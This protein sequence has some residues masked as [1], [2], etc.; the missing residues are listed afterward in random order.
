[1][2]NKD[3]HHLHD[4]VKKKLLVCAMLLIRKSEGKEELLLSCL[5][6]IHHNDLVAEITMTANEF[7]LLFTYISNWNISLNLLFILIA[8]VYLL[9]TGPLAA[10][11][12]AGS[13]VSPKKKLSFLFGLFL[14]YFSFGSPLAMLSHELFSMHM[15]QMS[16][17]YIVMP[18]FLLLGLPAWLVRPALGFQWVS[19]IGRFL[20]KPI[21]ILFV[22][23]GAI[24]LYHIPQVFDFL[25]SDMLYHLLSHLVLLALALCMWWPVVCPI[26]ELD[27]IKHLHKLGFIFANGVLLTPVCALIIFADQPL[28][29]TFREMS[30]VAPLMSPLHD[31][32]LGG[33]IMKIAQEIVYITAIGF[34]F[35]RWFRIQRQ[36]DEQEMLEWQQGEVSAIGKKQ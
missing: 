28:F 17:L 31:Q 19:R 11:F 15:L 9:I 26:P 24:S 27:R 36:K 35:S 32:V 4:L 10:K 25:M 29:A 34:I 21:V 33:V 18:P 16:L 22:F 12:P 30:N 5:I 20:T 23:N 3:S 1:M 13:S 6:S 8:V 14:Y 2:L 7:F